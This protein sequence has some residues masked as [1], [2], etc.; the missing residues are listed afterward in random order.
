MKTLMMLVATAGFALF[1]SMSSPRSEAQAGDG[2]C[3]KASTLQSRRAELDRAAGLIQDDA[4]AS[5]AA[6]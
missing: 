3:K 1:F 4:C 5:N 2:Q 6:H